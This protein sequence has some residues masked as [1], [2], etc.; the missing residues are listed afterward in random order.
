[1]PTRFDNI[2]RFTTAFFFLFIVFGTADFVFAKALSINNTSPLTNATQFTSYS[3]TFTCTG[4]GGATPPYTWSIASGTL[5][6]GLTLAN[7]NNAPSYDAVL[8]G[9]PTVSGT[10]TFSVFVQDSSSPKTKS[11]TVSFT[12]TILPN[13]TFSGASTGS[14]SFV[15]FDPS[16]SPG[17]ITNTV[18]SQVNFLCGTGLAYTIAVTSPTGQLQMT[19]ANLIPFTLGLAAAG[20]SAS[21]TTLI[22]LLTTASQI[23][24]YNNFVAGSSS[25]GTITVQISW[26]G[27]ATGSM[28]ATINVASAIVM[29]TCNNLVNGSIT[30]NID[31]SS[32]GPLTPN[33]TANGTPPT[34]MCTNQ[35]VHGISCTSSHGNQLTIGNDGATDPIAYTITGCPASVAGSGFLTTT[36]INFG[37]SLIATGAGGYQNAM[38]GAHT[39]TITVLVTY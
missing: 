26:S 31:P 4:I 6:A 11:N 30:F 23:S 7:L 9:T 1:M 38:A 17:P 35:A 39:D 18:T 19:G 12:L 21:D 8:S 24:N 22:P 25:I 15:N 33:T 10:F 29:D 3:Y 37:L 34:V 20:T 13:C 27:A 2:K 16:I 5:P 28:T 36:P 14:I 32:S